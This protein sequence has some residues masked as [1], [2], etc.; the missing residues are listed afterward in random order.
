MPRSFAT[1]T[2]HTFVFTAPVLADV[3]ER[4]GFRAVGVWSYDELSVAERIAATGAHSPL[5][6]ALAGGVAAP[7]A[8]VAR[9][10]G[11]GPYLRGIFVRT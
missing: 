9:V 11:R 6:R 2:E 3:F 4:R 5:R 7:A 1:S 10:T 8:L